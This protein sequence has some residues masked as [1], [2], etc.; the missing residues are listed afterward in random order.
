MTT[1]NAR[2]ATTARILHSRA[3]RTR[4]GHH[5]SVARRLA[6]LDAHVARFNAGR[7][8]AASYLTETLGVNADFV[9]RFASGFGKAA[10]AAHRART[11]NDPQRNC[12]ARVGRRR[13]VQCSSYD[14]CDLAEAARTF[15]RTA[16]FLNA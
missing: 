4:I 2:L 10:T 7:A 6:V 12:I 8:T 13:F 5:M 15:A 11:G 3:V 1:T 9:R 14:L 16:A